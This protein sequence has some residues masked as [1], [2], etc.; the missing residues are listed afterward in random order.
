MIKTGRILNY[1]A[2]STALGAS[3]LGGF[4]GQVLAQD[5]ESIDNPL[6]EIIVTARKRSESLQDVPLAITAFSEL[7]IQAN[8]MLD[9]RDIANVTP[10]L[11]YGD[12]FGRTAE[13]PTIRGMSNTSTDIEQPVAVFIDGVYQSTSVLA[14]SLSDLERVEVVKGPQSAL[15]GR[16]TFGGAINFVRKRPTNELDA[17]VS[18]SMGEDNYDAYTGSISGAVIKDKLFVRAGFDV[19]SVDGQYSDPNSGYKFGSEET[20]SFN[21]GLV[22]QVTE[23]LEIIAN[24]GKENV[25]DAL[26]PGRNISDM[27][28]NACNLGG[29]TTWWCGE[30]PS[31]DSG[32]I[33]ADTDL[34]GSKAGNARDTDRWD[35]TVNYHFPNQMELTTIFARADTLERLGVDQTYSSSE[36][37]GFPDTGLTFVPTG[38]NPGFYILGAEDWNTLDWSDTE[39][40]SAEARLASS[41]ERSWRWMVGLY[42]YDETQLDA[43]SAGVGPSYSLSRPAYDPPEER[44]GRAF[45]AWTEYDINERMTVSAEIRSLTEE[46][47]TKLVIP[48]NGNDKIDEDWDETTVRLSLSYKLT[49]DVTAYGSVATGFKA[50]GV[51]NSSSV[52]ANAPELVAYDPDTVTTYELGLKSDLLDNHLRVNV[53]AYYSDWEDQQLSTAVISGSNVISAIT[54]VGTTDIYGIDL[55]VAWIPVDGLKLSLAYAY[56]DAE[57][58]EGIDALRHFS[59]YGNSDLSGF[60]PPFIADNQ[61]TFSAS[62]TRPLMDT[63]F[64][65]YV[66][67]NYSYADDGR[68]LQVQNTMDLGESKSLNARFGFSN[69]NWDIAFWGKNLTDDDAAVSGIRYIDTNVFSKT[70]TTVRQPVALY[71]KKRQIGATVTYRF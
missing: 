17:K 68:Y 39:F 52:I 45:F 7:E 65:F 59:A 47:S 64:D 23:N 3:L 49:D 56:V 14:T 1:S 19:N 62:Y 63:G 60:E 26:F 34:L 41:S 53:A 15:Y 10:G 70:F 36:V 8:G 28:G 46:Y 4:A 66:N 69:D 12:E 31:N 5:G 61:Y 38:P 55:D 9:I 67:G 32:V 44:E 43:S 40:N 57:I 20:D 27:P 58:Q 35:V 22:Y 29:T 50:G 48:L 33:S 6:E 16:S 2:I 42:Y 18:V 25:N 37:D 13:R 30:L 71:G 54:N 21:L 51:N 24:Y 11:T